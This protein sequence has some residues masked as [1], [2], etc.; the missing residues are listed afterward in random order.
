MQRNPRDKRPPHTYTPEQF[1]ITAE[2]IRDKFAKYPQQYIGMA[3]V[4]YS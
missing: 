1:G 3:E 4:G 2:G